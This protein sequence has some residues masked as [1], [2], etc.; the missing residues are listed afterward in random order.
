MNDDNVSEK[1]PDKTRFMARP[2]MMI[3]VEMVEKMRS[4]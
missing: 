1:M 3:L 4:T 2:A